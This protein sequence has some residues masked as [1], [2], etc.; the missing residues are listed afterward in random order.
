[1]QKQVYRTHHPVFGEVA[2]KIGKYTSARELERIS[3]EVGLLRSVD[4]EY[5]PKQ[6]LFEPK[7]DSRYCI[8]EELIHGDSLEHHLSEY[9]AINTA[10]VHCTA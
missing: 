7:S 8:V 3:R 4:S 9:A 10:L 5:F 1:M 2:V 6:F